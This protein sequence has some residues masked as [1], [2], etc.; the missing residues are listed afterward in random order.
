MSAEPRSSHEVDVWA[1]NKFAAFQY[2]SYFLSRKA[3]LVHSVC[4][5]GKHF[6]APVIHSWDKSM[7]PQ[8]G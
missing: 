5:S 3:Y 7:G 8:D 6:T 2:F 4:M 1:S